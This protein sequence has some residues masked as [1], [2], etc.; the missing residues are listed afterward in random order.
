MRVG[1]SDV[2]PTLNVVSSGR[3]RLDC[4]VWPRGN[5][6]GSSLNHIQGRTI[7]SQSYSRALEQ[8]PLVAVAD[9]Q[10]AI[11]CLALFGNGTDSAVHSGGV[12][13]DSASKSDYSLQPTKRSTKHKKL[14]R[15]RGLPGF[16]VLGFSCVLS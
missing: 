5:W 3:N 12:A 14:P 11:I 10:S 15:E 2:H 16:V 13:I 1:F 4:D 6:L 7:V 8:G 9:L